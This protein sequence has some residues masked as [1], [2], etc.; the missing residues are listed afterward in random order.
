MAAADRNVAAALEEQS[1]GTLISVRVSTGSD[2]ARFPA[3][4]DQ[5]RHQIE[6]RVT[7]APQQGKANREL[8]E[9]VAGFFDV[10]SNEVTL[11]RGHTSREK[12]IHVRRPVDAVVQRLNN[13]L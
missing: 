7:A 13:G 10:A 6:A 1:N 3:G 4:Y 2:S 11:A 8:L 9:L 5:W 12:R